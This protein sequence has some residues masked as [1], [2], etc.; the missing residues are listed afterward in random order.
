MAGRLR[1]IV[2][3]RRYDILEA[4]A[5]QHLLI[6]LIASDTALGIVIFLK[7]ETFV[8]YKP[9]PFHLF[10]TVE[11]FISIHTHIRSEE[12]TSELQS[13]E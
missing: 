7:A 9:G 13:R 8:T 2:P 10:K 5:L 11:G 12:H 6:E 3:A 1:G 4:H